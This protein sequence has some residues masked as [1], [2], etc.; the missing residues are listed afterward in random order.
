MGRGFQRNWS[1]KS[2]P[3]GDRTYCVTF[4]AKGLEREGRVLGHGHLEEKR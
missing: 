3:C 2:I 1:R 4:S